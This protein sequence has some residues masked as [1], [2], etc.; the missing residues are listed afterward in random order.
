MELSSGKKGKSEALF[1]SFLISANAKS[2]K[3]R[4]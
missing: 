4:G 2:D 1:V 3:T